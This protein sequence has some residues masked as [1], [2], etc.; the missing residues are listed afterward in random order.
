MSTIIASLR[1]TRAARIA[2]R[3]HRLDLAARAFAAT[4]QPTPDQANE[5][6][7]AAQAAG[8]NLARVARLIED[9][10]ELARIEA[11]APDVAP[12]RERMLSARHALA[13]YDEES[14]G[15]ELAIIAARQPWKDRTGGITHET[16]TSQEQ[17]DHNRSRLPARAP[18]AQ[19]FIA[20]KEALDEALAISQRINVLRS[21]TTITAPV[22]AELRI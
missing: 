13:A 17:R 20:A 3:L 1:Q 14:R 11:T 8:F 19:A 22:G 5:L 7:E 2:E 16:G 12:L 6:D 15:G 21:E 10:R 18:L 4:H 9:L